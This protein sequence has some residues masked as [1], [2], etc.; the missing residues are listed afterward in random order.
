MEEENNRTEK[1]AF[2]DKKRP[3]QNY[4]LLQSHAQGNSRGNPEIQ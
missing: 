1:T 4:E 3:K 2:R